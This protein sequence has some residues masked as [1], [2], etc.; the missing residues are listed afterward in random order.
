MVQED[1]NANE[2]D[3]EENV[4]THPPTFAKAIDILEILYYIQRTDASGS[5]YFCF[6]KLKK[7]IFR[8][9]CHGHKQTLILDYLK[10]W[11]MKLKF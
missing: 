10:M 11:C 8:N 1:A 2:S 9:K 7:D 5:T 3:N 6:K 4:E